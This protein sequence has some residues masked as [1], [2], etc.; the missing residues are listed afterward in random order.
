MPTRRSTRLAASSLAALSALGLAAPP[1]AAADTFEAGSLI[2]PMDTDTQD[3]GIF[4]AYG[5]V[6]ELLMNGVPVRWVIKTGKAKGDAD[7]TVAATDLRT[8]ADLRSHGYRGGP[9]VIDSADVDAALPIVEAWLDQNPD[10]NV[11]EEAPS[12]RATSPA[13]WWSRRRSR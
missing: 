5:L 8:M 11:H 1:E 13:S 9:W 7:F 3:M 6:Y 10:T 4:E 2:I 12:S